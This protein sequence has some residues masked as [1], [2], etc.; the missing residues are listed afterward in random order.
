M[1]L[2]SNQVDAVFWSRSYVGVQTMIDES[3]DWTE[4]FDPEGEEDAAM[5]KLI[6]DQLVPNFDYVGCAG[7]DI[8][9]GLIVTAC[10]YTDSTVLV[11][12]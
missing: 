1:A 2:A 11:A 4:L 10:Y 12:K 9:D 8:T 6:N 3:I 7:K 5:L